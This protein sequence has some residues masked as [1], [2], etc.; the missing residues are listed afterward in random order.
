MTRNQI[1]YL[2][3]LATQD[4]NRE[5][6][7]ANLERERQGVMSL[8]ENYRHNVATEG[9]QQDQVV[10]LGRHNRATEGIQRDTLSETRR[11]NLA[12][13]QEQRRSNIA[14]EDLTAQQIR[15]GERTLD[16]TRRS[17]LAREAE[18]SR[19]NLARES[20][21]T[22]TNKANEAI[23]IGEAATK[24]ASA[25]EDARANRARETETA[26]HNRAMEL[27]DY[28]TRVTNTVAP[29]PST[30]AT[31]PSKGV[32]VNI[33]GQ[34][35]NSSPTNEV[36]LVGRTVEPGPSEGLVK[37]LTGWVTGSKT[38]YATERYSNGSQK[39]YME[40]LEHGKIIERKEISASEFARKRGK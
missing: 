35:S 5:V 15:L 33:G 25:A 20:E 3:V 8:S 19:S 18:T 29:T 28:S 39:Y 14:H 13:E 16:E 7:R 38:Q 27:K 2:K 36:K 40:V 12:R 1:E 9:I 10:E 17:N 24:A 30:V 37:G 26:L 31:T 32:T 23:R 11:S 22:R 34:K 21:N 4:A 6:Q